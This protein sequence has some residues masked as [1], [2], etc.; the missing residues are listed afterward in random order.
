MDRQYATYAAEQAA[1]LLEV[2]SPTGFTDRAADWVLQAFRDLGFSARMTGKGGVLIDLGG[3]N[4]DDAP[5]LEA[6]ADTLGAMVA[7]VKST[8]R[9]RITPLGAERQ[10][11]RDGK[12]AGVYPGRK[13]LEGTCQLCNASIHVNGE[14]ASTN[15]TFDTVEVVLDDQ[16]DSAEEAA[17]LGVQVGDVVCLEPRTRITRTGYIKSRFW[18]TSCRWAFCWAWPNTWPTGRYAG[19]AGLHPC[20]RL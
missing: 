18:T 17:A 11:R 20:D 14:Y 9:L 16:A 15:R 8:G 10:Q 1:K 2:D 7:E 3:R 5:L 13:V 6:H 19:A 12:R 4:A